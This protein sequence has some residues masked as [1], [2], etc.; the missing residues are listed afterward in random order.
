MQQGWDRE[1]KPLYPQPIRWRAGIAFSL[2]LAC[3]A[4]SF[5]GYIWLNEIDPCRGGHDNW[6]S[7]ADF[8]AR[9]TGISFADA[10]RWGALGLMM[11]IVA[12]Q[13]WKHRDHTH[14]D[15]SRG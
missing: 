6:C 9:T 13:L 5:A 10:Q 11:K 2:L 4:F 3:G 12:Y 15:R 8:W 14:L 7:M 1:T